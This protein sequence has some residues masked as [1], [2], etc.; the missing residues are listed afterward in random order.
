M[1]GIQEG[2]GGPGQAEA[3]SCP[4][5]R[6]RVLFADDS[7]SQRALVRALLGD[8][9][10]VTV[11]ADG[12]E[13]LQIA[14]RDR[15]EVILSDL[16]MPGLSGLEL[17]RYLKSDETLRR[18]PIILVTGE[19]RAALTT[20]RAGA[21]DYLKKPYGPEE[22]RAR[23][24][25]AARS[26][27]MYAELERQHEEL[28]QSHAA[29]RKLQLELDQAQKLEAV[30][31]LASGIA[32]EINTPVQF[33]SDN[34]RFLEDA[35]K[36]MGRVLDAQRQ[37]LQGLTPPPEVAARLAAAVEEADLT[38]VLEQLPATF[39]ETGEGL[40]R[41][42]SLVRA[43]KEFAHPDQKT[44]VPTDLNR[45]LQATLEVARNEYKYVADVETA[46]GEIPPVTCHAGDVNQVFLNILVNAAHAVGDVMKQSGKKG[47]IKVVTALDPEGVRISISDSGGGIP[48]AVRPRVYDQFF[49]TKEVGRGTG[50]GLAIARNIVAQHHGAIWFDTALGQGTTFHVRLPIQGAPADPPVTP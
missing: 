37:V 49:T 24:G 17:V 38:Y 28:V 40:R 35:F 29:S 18:I 9:C 27:R 46:Y 11:T 45:A 36:A 10:D 22:L 2:F 13:A 5:L 50:Q 42:A 8:T 4:V 12:Q 30:G 33:V 43:M 23:V 19:E 14:R 32:H 7:A 20:M 34:V 3:S 6:T 48:E 47:T 44:M 31:R 26:Y 1:M 25:A 16:Q 15:P 39:R 41:V 21:D